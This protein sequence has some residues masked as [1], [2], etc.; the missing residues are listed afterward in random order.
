MKRPRALPLYNSILSSGL[1][2]AF[3]LSSL[4]LGLAFG[5]HALGW[6]GTFSIVLVVGTRTWA[7]AGGKRLIVR[8]ALDRNHVFPG[9]SAQLRLS[10][11]N[12][13]MLPLRARIEAALPESQAGKENPGA[14][15]A[16]VSR[17]F[18]RT[19]PAKTR[20]D[21]TLEL[22]PE[23]RGVHAFGELGVA[24][25]DPFGFFEYGSKVA[26]CSELV[27]YPRVFPL[28]K[29]SFPALG[30]FGAAA[31]K[32]PVE[33]PAY[34]AGVRDHRG[35][36]PARSIHWKA[37][38]HRGK[39]QEKI[40]EPTARREICLIVDVSGFE[41]GGASEEF[42]IALEAAASIAFLYVGGGASVGYIGNGLSRTGNSGI[43]RAGKGGDGTGEILDALARLEMRSGG[44]IA[45]L[46]RRG[47]RTH[48]YSTAV[49]FGR[50]YGEA[51]SRLRQ[52][53]SRIPG[54][55]L[56]FILTGETTDPSPSQTTRTLSPGDI[57]PE[58]RRTHG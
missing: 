40:F 51:A 45:E 24:A 26:T 38:A 32:S 44:D 37:S 36:R 39:L 54:L 48:R 27:V 50:E 25:G 43:I 12:R 29:N 11:E 41:T 17:L 30:F 19:I 53:L 8:M 14:H 7:V 35:E 16:P 20:T 55:S 10:I 23:K 9:E 2:M 1:A 52:A 22:H 5:Q 28:D 4:V 57:R 56:S 21:R 34:A 49:Y 13:S 58:W 33:D 31:V 42:E 47:F 18:D 46:A 15:A 6:L 3:A